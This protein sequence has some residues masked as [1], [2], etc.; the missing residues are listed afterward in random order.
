MTYNGN[1]RKGVEQKRI[2]HPPVWL[3]N[4]FNEGRNGQKMGL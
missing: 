1:A 3:Y 4:E 2:C